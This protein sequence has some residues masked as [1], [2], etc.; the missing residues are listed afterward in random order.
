M[1]E[2]YKKIAVSV[3][4]KYLVRLNVMFAFKDHVLIWPDLPKPLNQLIG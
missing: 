4:A 1:T 2:P 3:C